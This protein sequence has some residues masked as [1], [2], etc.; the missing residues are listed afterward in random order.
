MWHTSNENTLVER[1]SGT[2]NQCW[3]EHVTQASFNGSDGIEISYAYL[4]PTKPKAA[5]VFSN[6][7][8]ETFC[9]YKE[10]FFECFQNDIALFMMDHRG[11][12]LSGRMVVDQQ[13]GYIK[14]FEDFIGDL[15]VFTREV[16]ASKV[17]IKPSL[18]CHSMGSAI[19]FLTANRYP[20]LFA[21]CVFC[22]PMFGIRSG[23]P[24]P[25]LKLLLSGGLAL[26]Q[27]VGRKPWYIFGQ[28][29]YIEIPFAIN[30]LTHSHTRY[31]LFRDEYKRNPR[32]QLGGVTYQWVAAAKL[33]M[34]AIELS[35]KSF[36]LDT[37]VFISGADKVVDNRRI[38]RVAKAIP[39]AEIKIVDG[40]RHELFFEQDEYREPFINK[41]FDY[42]TRQ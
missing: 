18:V 4:L 31:R 26:N 15:A 20:D 29:P 36:P 13:R 8:I 22:S 16:V 10:F 41:L 28:G 33:A 5:I 35:A 40:A 34:D 9:K 12:G 32:I 17:D 7:R 2:I 25:I 21:R 42:I 19:G 24:A 30:T 39:K 27:M 6:G 3:N 1:Y 14:R 37:L 11:Q 23:I 38:E